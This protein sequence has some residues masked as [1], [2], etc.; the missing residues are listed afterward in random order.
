MTWTNITPLSLSPL[1][2]HILS[3]YPMAPTYSLLQL[4]FF[5]DLNNFIYLLHP[6]PHIAFS[7]F[8]TVIIERIAL[9]TNAPTVML[10][11]Q[12]TQLATVCSSNAT[13]IGI[14]VME[15][16][17]VPITTVQ[18]VLNRG[19]SWVIVHLNAYPLHSRL[20]PMEGLLPPPSD[21][22][23]KETFIIEPGAR[24]YRRGNVTIFLLFHH[25]LLVLFNTSRHYWRGLRPL[26]DSYLVIM[27]PTSLFLSH[28]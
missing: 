22:S 24:L 9:N 17:S 18:L 14:G 25:I 7:I 11:P 5:P 13:F 19:I 23:S 6:W 1:T 4:A 2:W 28:L 15:P 10:P 12:A 27:G 26:N 8:T 21:Y 20:P 3:I 16:I